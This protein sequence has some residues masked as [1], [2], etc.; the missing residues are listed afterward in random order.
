METVGCIRWV[1]MRPSLAPFIRRIC[2]IFDPVSVHFAWEGH[3]LVNDWLKVVQYG[4]SVDLTSFL[5]RRRRL[6]ADHS[7]SVCDLACRVMHYW[8]AKVVVSV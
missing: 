1:K 2:W 4:G 6:G 8:S 7:A 3:E 5:T